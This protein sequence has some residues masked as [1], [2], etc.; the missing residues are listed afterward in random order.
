MQYH[1]ESDALQVP[2]VLLDSLESHVLPWERPTSSASE[3][4]LKLGDVTVL[5]KAQ[6]FQIEVTRGHDTLMKLNG[7][8]LFQFEHL[9]EK[10]ASTAN[11]S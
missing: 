3:T 4:K 5:L 6:P 7:R 9:R 1:S 11:V 10:K 8:G 2:F